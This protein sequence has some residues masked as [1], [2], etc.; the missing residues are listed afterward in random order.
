MGTIEPKFV[1]TPAQDN[2]KAISVPIET[3]QIKPTTREVR[4]LMNE[5]RNVRVSEEIEK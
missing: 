5:R 4:E 2:Q 1:R 3:S